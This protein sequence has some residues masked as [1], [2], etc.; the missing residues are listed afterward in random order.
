MSNDKLTGIY[1]KNGVLLRVDESNEDNSYVRTWRKGTNGTIK[2]DYDHFI[3]A[4]RVSTNFLKEELE[5]AKKLID[6]YS[7]WVGS[8]DDK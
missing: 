2:S 5:S 7:S 6:E 8:S 3:G 4:S 1:E